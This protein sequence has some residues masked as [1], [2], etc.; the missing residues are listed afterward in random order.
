MPQLQSLL[1]VLTPLTNFLSTFLGILH[2]SSNF[3][4]SACARLNS[5]RYS[6]EQYEK[7]FSLILYLVL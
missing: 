7:K 3:S 1:A 5:A 2:V 4:R 6:Y